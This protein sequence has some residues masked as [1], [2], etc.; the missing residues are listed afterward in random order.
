MV[1]FPL[2][3]PPSLP[4]QVRPLWGLEAAPQPAQ[5]PPA[6]EGQ[7]RWPGSLAEPQLDNARPPPLPLA[8]VQPQREACG[9]STLTTPQES[10]C[11]YMWAVKGFIWD[12]GWVV[13]GI[14]WW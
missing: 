4:R 3:P 14:R 12:V 8:A 13:D 6:V 5:C 9:G 11:E 7:A 2:S 1:T 10:K